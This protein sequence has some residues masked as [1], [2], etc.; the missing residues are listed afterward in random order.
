[1]RQALQDMFINEGYSSGELDACGQDA[2]EWFLSDTTDPGS[3]VWV[4]DILQ[5]Q[6]WMLRKWLST[7]H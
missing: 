4:C 1:M 3:L 2:V 5:I 6:P 7:Y